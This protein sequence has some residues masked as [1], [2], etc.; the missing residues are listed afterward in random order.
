[1]IA[2]DWGTSSLRGY[3]LGADGK[4]RAQRRG[5]DGIL[6]CQGRFDEVLAG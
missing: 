5:S 1:M 6:A 4:V 2:I 3:L